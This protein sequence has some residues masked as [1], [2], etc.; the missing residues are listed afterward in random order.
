MI[1]GMEGVKKLVPFS[2]KPKNDVLA[3]YST[4]SDKCFYLLVAIVLIILLALTS[5]F[6]TSQIT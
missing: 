5:I 2:P 3:C 1:C 6:V 4:Q